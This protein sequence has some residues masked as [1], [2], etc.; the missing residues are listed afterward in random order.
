MSADKPN[1]Y[2]VDEEAGTVAEQP[3]SI[4]LNL[5]TSIGRAVFLAAHIA[6]AHGMMAGRGVPDDVIPF[7]VEMMFTDEKLLGLIV[8]PP[9]APT[10]TE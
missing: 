6:D 3:V 1:L 10:P 4:Q 7:Y 5:E 9:K 8:Q 2:V